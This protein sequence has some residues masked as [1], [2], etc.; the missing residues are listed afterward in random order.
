[1][2]YE[3][4]K[5]L[6]VLWIVKE[7]GLASL[8]EVAERYQEL[9]EEEY[10]Q[11]N[12][13]IRRWKARK[14]FV[15]EQNRYKIANIPPWFRS[16]RMDQLIHLNKKESKQILKDLEDLFTGGEVVGGK[17]PQWRDFVK[18]QLTFEAVDPI[19]GGTP[20]EVNGKTVF[21]R[22]G[23]KLVVPM[24]WLKGLTRD[25]SALMNVVGL[26]YHVAWAKGYWED[27]IETIIMKAPVT[28]KGKGVGVAKYESVPA[29]KKFVVLVR[30]PMKG[31]CIN[32]VEKIQEWF[33]MIAETPIKGLGANPKAYGGRI[34]LVEIKEI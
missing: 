22:E 5:E 21:P 33:D 10:K 27:G 34:R 26:H 23:D 3:P 15:M 16:L 14:A 7:L 18:L 25:N 20:S 31:C 32:S 13:V 2:K 8:E 11:V 19:L 6:R 30:F 1:M 28:A 24:N 17:K 12:L 4:E 29:G 9:F